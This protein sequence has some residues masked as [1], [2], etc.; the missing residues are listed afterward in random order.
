MW[1]C[2]FEWFE[3]HTFSWVAWLWSLSGGLWIVT[4]VWC[5]TCV[6][7]NVTRWFC[8]L[9]VLMGFWWNFIF[10]AWCV[11]CWQ[12]IILMLH[13]GSVCLVWRVL[14]ELNVVWGFLHLGTQWWLFRLCEAVENG[15]LRL[16]E[17][18][19]EDWSECC[20]LLPVRSRVERKNVSPYFGSLR[21]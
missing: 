12:S 2:E 3:C 9:N 20:T 15:H 16:Y 4:G 10:H 7:M 19:V 21:V 13:V 8:Y 17:A 5:Y 18:V 1:Q 14:V 6:W 11:F